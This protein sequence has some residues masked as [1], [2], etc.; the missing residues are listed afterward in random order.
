VIY[1]GADV[2]TT[3]AVRAVARDGR[4]YP[5]PALILTRGAR[6]V[7]FGPDAHSIVLLRGEVDHKNFW[8]VDLRTGEERQLTE[9]APDIGISDF[10]LSP[11]G[12][13]I[14]FD[15]I[16]RSSRVARIERGD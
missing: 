11:D 2:D 13:S 15:R 3:F 10:Y 14:P 12:R 8:R 7:G 16:Q 5:I 4:P 6:R 9:L 1:S